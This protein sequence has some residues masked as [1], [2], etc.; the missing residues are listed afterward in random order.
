MIRI[1]NARVRSLRGR[2]DEGIAMVMV[3]G[4][5]VVLMLLVS[6]ALGVSLS[7]MI[8]SKTDETWNGAVAAAYAGIDDYKSKLA[9]DAAYTQYGNPAAPF[10]AGAPVV[11][12]P[13]VNPAF[14]L[15]VDGSWA[16]IPGPNEGKKS[17]YR[18]EVDNSSYDKEGTLRVRSTG[19][20]GAETR[21][22]IATLKQ[23]GFIDFLYYTM[24]EIQEPPAELKERC[25]KYAWSAG[26]RN[27]PACKEI[28]F[29]A[30][31]KV[32]GPVHSNDI[33]RICG[34]AVFDG[35]V[36]T[37]YDPV[38]SGRPAGTDAYAKIS[39]NGTSAGCGGEIFNRGKPKVR[40]TVDL[41][42]T[43]S[44]MRREVRNDLGTEVPDPGCLYTGPTRITF[45]GDGTMTVRSPWTK[46]TQVAGDPATSGT[47]PAKCGAPGAAG[48]GSATGARISVLDRNLIFVQNVPSGSSTDPNAWAGATQ[49]TG[50]TAATCGQGNGL[51]YPVAGEYVASIPTSYGCKNGDVFVEGNIKGQLTIASENNTYVTGDIR[52][53]DDASMLGLVAQNSVWVWNPVSRTGPYWDPSYGTYYSYSLLNSGSRVIQAAIVSVQH[54]FQVQNYD[55]GGMRGDLTV[56]GAIAQKFRGIVRGG[57]NGFDKDYRYDKRLEFKAPPKFLSPVTS[58]FSIKNIAEVK[59]AFNADGTI[60]P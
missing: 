10:S 8:K 28:A 60:I 12:P 18:Y 27:D 32:T 33:I 36:T 25:E 9:N 21:S 45:N 43:N 17:Q 44:A 26:G 59:T 38:K 57:D 29:G 11:L 46:V 22:I 3:L 49:P 4:I 7:G 40:E 2:A 5:S 54:T 16:S 39:S 19:R 20:V 13:A 35:E 30:R 14:G 52:Y 42:P 1:L 23:T 6:V 51:G 15:G 34:R 50:Y 53:Q 37:S 56:V 24:Y 41:P 55:Q 47:S 58:T 48:L 31:D